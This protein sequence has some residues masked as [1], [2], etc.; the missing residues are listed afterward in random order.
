MQ[1][2][3]YFPPIQS[4]QRREP[5]IQR[6]I[7]QI[8]ADGVVLRLIHTHTINLRDLD[9]IG[10]WD[11]QWYHARLERNRHAQVVQPYLL[12]FFVALV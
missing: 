8:S 5:R 3:S 12:I 4:D 1:R 10:F 6:K 9:D 2:Q 11:M 7:R